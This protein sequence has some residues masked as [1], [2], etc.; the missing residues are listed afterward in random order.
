MDR[1]AARAPQEKS[2]QAKMLT[3]SAWMTAGSMFSRVLG[4][5]YIIPWYIWM[6]ASAATAN[7]LFVKGYSVYAIF[8]MI[9][10]AGIPGAVSKQIARYDAMGEYSTSMR[11]F[12]HGMLATSIMGVLGA[13]I[14]WFAAPILAAGDARMVPIFHTLSLALVLIPM[15]SILR[16]FFQGHS[17]M[18]PSAISQFLEQLVRVAYMLVTAYMI[19][20]V[21]NRDYVEAVKQSTF[22]AF[23]GAIAGIALLAFLL[24]KR[25]PQ[26]RRR[27]AES[28]NEIHVSVNH[29]LWEVVQQ[30]IPFIILSAT[31]NVYYLIDQYTFFT[32]MKSLYSTT[33]HALNIYYAMF[34]GNANKLVTIV[35]S[36]AAGM[37]TTAIPLLTTAWTKHKMHEVTNQIT[38]AL[39]LL[40]FVIIPASF[41]MAAISHPLYV[42]F[43]DY[44]EIGFR[45]LEISCVMAIF[46]GMFLVLVG[47]LQGL[48]QNMRAIWEM[49][50]GMA[51]KV[52]LQLPFMYLFNVYGPM[53]ATIAGAGVSCALM[54][55]D[56][57][58]LYHYKGLQTLKRVVGITAFSII[59]F[60]ATRLTVVGLSQIL[61]PASKVQSAIILI[62]ALA[63]GVGIYVYLSLTTRLADTIMGK[64]V[65]KIRRMLHIR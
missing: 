11:L 5:I 23:V 52:I 46:L 41:G 65:G 57:H 2:A 16:G 36:L 13:A 20:K 53:I 6:G 56:L 64:R 38:N 33:M 30:A 60:I 35:V 61:N 8:I 31:I 18:A 42:I 3:G 12:W 4:A 62:P 39:Q 28:R 10:T 7:S 14:M 51:V 15:L 40:F 9:S 63:V 55:Y 22:G 58:H 34:A 44:N 54:L 49:L 59:M 27:N 43:Y 21:G 1:K 37:S 17:E 25:M 45:M 48:F 47:I 32:G 29:L 50:A 19:M 24:A 26:I